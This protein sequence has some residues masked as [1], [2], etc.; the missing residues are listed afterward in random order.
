MIAKLT[1]SDLSGLALIKTFVGGI[2]YGWFP[3]A[4]LI[5]FVV[6]PILNSFIKSCS[7]K[8]FGKYILYFYLLSTIGGYLL[9]FQDYRKGMS[10]LSLMGLYLIGAYLRVSQFGIR[11]LDGCDSFYSILSGYIFFYLWVFESDSHTDVHLS[12][13]VL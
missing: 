11:H 8:E 9:G 1:Y 7:E 3:E 12:V 13:P 10:A 4:Y 5:L 6:S 2:V